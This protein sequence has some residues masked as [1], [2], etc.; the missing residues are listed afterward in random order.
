MSLSDKLETMRFCVQCRLGENLGCS[1]ELE[2]KWAIWHKTTLAT[3]KESIKK[4]KEHK[5]KIGEDESI[6][7]IQGRLDAIGIFNHTIDKICG[8]KLT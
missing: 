4:L 5:E 7:Y 2:Y 3:V 1:C 8:E 6:A